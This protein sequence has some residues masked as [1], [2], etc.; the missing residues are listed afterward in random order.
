[1]KWLLIVFSAVLLVAAAI[2]GLSRSRPS[3]LASGVAST[4]ASPGIYKAKPY[5]AIV[6]VPKSV[7]NR[8]VQMPTSTNDF[9]IR[10]TGPNLRLE[11]K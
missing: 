7:D 2:L 4:E 9:A 5:S 8:S 10:S 3:Q 1:M 6:L 11:S